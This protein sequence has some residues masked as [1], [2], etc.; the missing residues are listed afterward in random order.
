MHTKNA[1]IVKQK[2]RILETQDRQCNTSAHPHEIGIGMSA[3][4]QIEHKKI[5]LEFNHASKSSGRIIPYMH[6]NINT[7]LGITTSSYRNVREF[8][9]QTCSPFLKSSK[10]VGSRRL[11]IST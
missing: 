5:K 2:L 10:V 9:E 3:S 4:K 1:S 7:F 6:A 8:I 11:K